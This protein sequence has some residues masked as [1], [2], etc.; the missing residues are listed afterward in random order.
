MFANKKPKYEK[1]VIT[2]EIK[3]LKDN[4][5]NNKRNFHLFWASGTR[6]TAFILYLSK[7]I[8]IYVVLQ[9]NLKDNWENQRK[10]YRFV[11]C[12]IHY[13]QMK[14]FKQKDLSSRLVVIDESHN[15]FHNMYR[16]DKYNGEYTKTICVKEDNKLMF[17][18]KSVNISQF[19]DI[20]MRDRYVLLSASVVYLPK[21]Y[22]YIKK[23]NPIISYKDKEEL[24]VKIISNRIKVNM[25]SEHFDVCEKVPD[26]AKKL[27]QINITG[28]QNIEKYKSKKLIASILQIGV[29]KNLLYVEYKCLVP[30]VKEYLNKIGFSNGDV[31]D[32]RKFN[33]VNNLN[34]ELLKVMIIT[35]SELV[36]F[37]F[38]NTNVL[39]ILS[40]PEYAIEYKQLIDRVL[41]YKT[42]VNLTEERRYLKINQIVSIND[43]NETYDEKL[44]KDIEIQMEKLSVLYEILKKKSIE[45]KKI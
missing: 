3:E 8:K 36:G 39:F 31:K 30:I 34:G 19:Q 23:L 28:F 33:S 16:A 43:N 44:I 1:Y 45:Y 38:P 29:G 22:H 26:N 25:D 18:E 7:F 41:R 2:D 40:I 12:K 17:K 20:K 6:K 32:I 42:H 10:R 24:D 13:I 9:E 14:H 21:E 5:I 4:I 27:Y 37:S 11:G 35:K 15:L